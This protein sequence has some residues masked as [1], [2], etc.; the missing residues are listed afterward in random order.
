MTCSTMTGRAIG[1]GTGVPASR[2]C[3]CCS[4]S[5]A[6][7]GAQYESMIAGAAAL[8]AHY[9][10]SAQNVMSH[11][12]YSDEGKIDIRNNMDAV[13]DDVAGS[14]GDEV[15]QMVLFK[16]Y[17]TQDKE[18]YWISGGTYWGYRSGIALSANFPI[19]TSSSE[20]GN[21]GVLQGLRRVG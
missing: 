6:I 1:P 18:W 9:G 11:E 12:E 17:N 14:G 13:R 3:C 21:E 16:A 7:S 8:V 10:L 20:G 5:D 2:S 15:G 4:G 19:I